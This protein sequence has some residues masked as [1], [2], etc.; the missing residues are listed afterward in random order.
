MYDVVK[1]LNPAGCSIFFSRA[2]EK[3]TYNV[4]LKDSDGENFNIGS[5]KIFINDNDEVE[6]KTKPSNYTES[7]EV[8]STKLDEAFSDSRPNWLKMTLKKQNAD[9]SSWRPALF[10]EDTE[11]VP[12]PTDKI[13][14]KNGLTTVAKE[15]Y[16]VGEAVETKMTESVDRSAMFTEVIQSIDNFLGTVI[17][18]VDPETLKDYVNKITELANGFIS[19][20][21]LDESNEDPVAFD[22]ETELERM[23]EDDIYYE[24]AEFLHIDKDEADFSDTL[25][26]MKN[27]LDELKLEPKR[28]LELLKQYQADGKNV[29][30]VLDDY[31]FGDID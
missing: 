16:A 13:K 26:S 28:Y 1:H 14:G 12:V 23:H 9:H 27:R 4:N 30:D 17:D 22:K 19:S 7:V 8:T 15:A 6:V 5:L 24:I 20:E 21:D 10:S 29:N 2:Y 11:F 31:E 18:E 3:D 25:Y